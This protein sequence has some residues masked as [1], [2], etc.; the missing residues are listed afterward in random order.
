MIKKT[1]KVFAIVLCITVLL[2]G[3]DFSKKSSKSDIADTSTSSQDST[4]KTTSALPSTIDTYAKNYTEVGEIFP[5]QTL[6]K[7]DTTETE[8]KE[9]KAEKQGMVAYTSNFGYTIEYPEIYEPK[10]NFNNTEFIILDENSGSNMNAIVT[11]PNI[12][13]ESE[14][15]YREA[16]KDNDTMK[17]K[18]F[19]VTEIN[20]I[21][22]VQLEIAIQGGYAYQT[23]YRTGEYY[24]VLT[25]VQGR[26]VTKTFDSDMRAIINSLS[27]K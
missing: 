14:E 16:T 3:C 5:S 13:Y 15:K 26:G 23:I 9:E 25:Y 4:E 6:T 2:C 11:Y 12:L 21:N 10:R 22:A 8:V 20:G 19:T 17:L 7:G 1:M 24:Y 27:F 18:K